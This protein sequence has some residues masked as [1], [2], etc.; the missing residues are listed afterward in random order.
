LFAKW[1]TEALLVVV[2]ALAP[3]S[4][5]AQEARPVSL[6]EALAAAKANNALLRAARLDVDAMEGQLSEAR[7]YR[8]PD[9][10]LSTGFLRTTSPTYVFMGKLG[11][12]SFTMMDFAIDGL[13]RPDPY[14]NWQSRA[15][16]TAPLFTGGKLAAAY[17][18]AK[19][20]VEAA[21]GTGEFAEA[22]VAK[23]VTEAFYGS[24]LALRAAEVTAEAVKTAEAHRDQVAAMRAEGMVLDSDFLRI[25]VF[26]ADLQQQRASR[27]ADTQVA[28]A[29][30]AYAM[31]EEG[32][33]E[34][35][36]EF[37]SPG[38][39]LPPLL[40]A[41]R[42]AEEQRGDLRA[43]ET[44]TA[45]AAEGV[46]MARAD[47]IPQVG[48]MAAWEWNTES[49]SSYGDNWAVG[50]QVKIPVFDGGGRSGKLRTAKAR[51]GQAQQGLLD[52]RQRIRVE[53]KDAW[54]RSRAAAERVAVTTGAA[55]QAKESLRIVELRYKEGLAPIT[56]LL[57]ADTA[58]LAAELTRA[59][60]VHDEIVARARLAWAMGEKQ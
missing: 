47:Y 3:I 10:D 24:L 58:L 44:Q 16:V 53:V 28:R 12:Q 40:E 8:I 4:A 27:D 26:V 13:N 35:R 5:S 41:Q 2:L 23:G 18:A 50:V 15:E 57:D 55:A 59:H 11:Q 46:K 1:S 22:S 6:E 36:G 32:D 43:M 45:Q 49:W 48:A 21:R 7:S 25:Q 31:G 20:G 34:P 52:L 17:R 29:Y 56:D 54:L 51:E 60:A 9:L 14:N 38:T 42:R 33:V 39:E 30:L 19:L 37:Q